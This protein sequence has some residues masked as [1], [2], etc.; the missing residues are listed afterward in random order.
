MDQEQLESIRGELERLSEG[1][2]YSAQAYFEAAKRAEFWG[3]LMIFLPAC[4]SAV[5]G[6]MSA[7]RKEEV[8][9]AISAVSGSVAATAAFLGTTKKAADFQLSARSYTILRHRLILES[10]ILSIGDDL[11][12][13]QEKLRSLGDAYM[14]IVANDVPVPNRSFSLARKRIHQGLAS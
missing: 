13:S 12:E 6:F 5:A 9:G 10:R 11:Q 1:C 7:L 2:L 4:I 8:W 14:Q 3:R